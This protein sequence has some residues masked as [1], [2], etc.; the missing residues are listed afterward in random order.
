[1]GIFEYS[2][3]ESGIADYLMR[4]RKSG[5]NYSRRDLDERIV[6][7]GDLA[8]TEKIIDSM[9]NAPGVERY[10][11]ITFSFRED[12]IPVETIEAINAEIKDFFLAGY[13][14]D[15][16]N[17]YSEAHLP[18]LKGYIDANGQ[19]VNRLAHIHIVIP[20][21]NLRDGRR[22]DPLALLSARFGGKVST[23]EYLDNFQEYLNEKYGLASPK[24]HPR[25]LGGVGVLDRHKTSQAADFMKRTSLVPAR[26]MQDV[27]RLDI[28]ST[29]ALKA[30]LQEHYGEVK[31]GRSRGVPY[32]KVRQAG[33]SKSIRLDDSVFQPDFLAL[34]PE[35]KLARLSRSG[36]LHKYIEPDPEKAAAAKLDA[37]LAMIE[38]WKV[39]RAREI[40]HLSPS[41]KFFKDVYRNLSPEE[42]IDVLDRLERGESVRGHEFVEAAPTSERLN[43]ITA[44]QVAENLDEGDRIAQ[45]DE[46]TIRAALDALTYNQSSF[47]GS[48][49]ESYLLQRTGG[50][51][52]YEKA[53]AAVLRNDY[54]SIVAT[55]EGGRRYTTSRILDIERALIDRTEKMAAGQ[56]RAAEGNEQDKEM[57]NEGQ[58]AAYDALIS[59]DLINVVNGA[60]GTGK[61]FVLAKANLA[62]KAAG[63]KVYGAI[64]QGKTAQDLMR[65]SGIE[66]RT[67]H[68]FLMRLETGS[69]KLDADSVVV[70]DEAGMVG[71]EQLNKLLGHCH[72]AGCQIRLVGD[73]AQVQAVTFGAAFD[74]ISDRVKVTK[75]T[76]IMRQGSHIKD[77]QSEEYKKLEW[78]R[79]ASEDF[80]QYKV[81]EA[82][83]AYDAHGMITETETRDGAIDFIVELVRAEKNALIIAKRNSDRRILNHLV[84]EN[85]IEDGL[86]DDSVAINAAGI[87]LGKGD[88]VMFTA[89]NK[90]LGVLNGT[91]GV[92][93]RVTGKSAFVKIDSGDLVEIAHGDDD[94]QLTYG[95]AVT[96]NKS[97]GASELAA[98]GLADPSMTRNDAYVTMTRHRERCRLVYAREDFADKQQLFKSLN[99]HSVKEFVGDQDEQRVDGNIVDRLL[100]EHSKS[101]ILTREAS[102]VSRKKIDAEL[103]PERLLIMLEKSHGLDFEKY[104][105][106]GGKIKAGSRALSPLEFLTDEMHMNPSEALPK[107]REAYRLQLEK[108]YL[109][110]DAKP[111]KT[112][113]KEFAQWLE[114]RE[115]KAKKILAGL[116][117]KA[118][119][120]KRRTADPEIKA[121]IDKRLAEERKE[122]KKLFEKPNRELFEDFR[123]E[124]RY[125][126]QIQQAEKQTSPP[127][128]EVEKQQEE[129]QPAA[130]A[131][132]PVE[133][134]EEQEE[135]RQRER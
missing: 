115:E 79:K 130:P 93:E 90:D 132:E 108:A 27:I 11:H 101:Q 52:D 127:A 121:E 75:L 12:H 46:E 37:R 23:A 36:D 48:E 77:R 83:E 43:K 73:V 133:V 10:H 71:S 134:E 18:K 114:Q 44:A 119:A 29:E 32:L 110:R 22:A 88:R 6:L 19:D 25:F 54:L 53:L 38:E 95:Y 106:E 31:I 3:G 26:V 98:F 112:E 50:E 74:K 103:E 16:V 109:D 35:E 102:R 99:R 15:E 33:D 135:Q 17:Y 28:R 21:I 14:D 40:R 45:G 104:Q 63:K 2:G 7:S 85:R 111:S 86:V 59:S 51:E 57:M 55:P 70:I 117:E 120:K 81:T 49:L 47:S 91:Q 39:M 66:S 67:I 8:V 80:S 131:V 87:R 123:K 58:G 20:K 124:K 92:I 65:D 116:T 5:R 72:D 13:G 105:V 129:K 89:P 30:H 78:M 100:N 61:S 113:R 24:D 4:G 126:E 107:L 122:V 96:V 64:L 42:K 97:Q 84:R 68:S 34:S 1:M 118:R 76:E 94:I 9:G 69:V 125:E 60:A 41:S 128:A 56:G 62:W 82:L